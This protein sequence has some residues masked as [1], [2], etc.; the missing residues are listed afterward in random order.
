MLFVKYVVLGGTGMM[1]R[2]AVR[3]LFESDRSNEIVIAGTD[4]RKAALSASAYKSARVSGVSVDVR[5][6]AS[7]SR[8]LKD[9]DAAVNCVQYYHNLAVMEGALK[10]GTHYVDLGGLYYTTLKQLK[11]HHRFRKEN[12]TAILGMGSTP[13]ITNVLAAWG[14]ERFD[15]IDSIDIKFGAADFS[16]TEGRPF[17]VP[18]SIS[19]LIDEFTIPPVIFK[20]GKIKKQKPL[21]G[22]EHAKF[23]H[24]IGTKSAFYTIHSELAT[25][26]SSFR[27]WGVK[28]VT[29]RVSFDHDFVEK[30]LF[31]ADTGMASG[32]PVNYEGVKIVPREFLAKVISNQPR[33][34]VKKLDD[35]EC[36]LVEMSGK[37]GGRRKKIQACCLAKSIP[38]WGVSAGD[39][40]TGTPPSIVAQMIGEGQVHEHGVFPPE[41]HIPTE[42]F[43]SEL[44]KRKMR[45]FIR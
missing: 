9:S 12:L 33:P 37:K 32:E 30:I 43:F 36:L 39:A 20:N 25:F 35:Y 19:T 21:S 40:D 26:P 8:I 5:D 34:K 11:L 3:D 4:P 17:P 41:F 24:P 31:M 45:I 38:E 27:S 6:R 10:A 29:F 7:L 15:R 23:P 18:Y 42:S 2:I 28:N 16:K 1:G 22:F 14:A 44:K 13:G